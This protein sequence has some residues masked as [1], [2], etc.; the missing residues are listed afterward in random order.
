VRRWLHAFRDAGL[1]G[2]LGRSAEPRESRQ[3]PTADRLVPVVPI[4]VPE[5]GRIF[6]FHWFN[7]PVDPDFFWQWLTWRR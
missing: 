5:L 6:V 4:S 2:L 7:H 3:R 1:V